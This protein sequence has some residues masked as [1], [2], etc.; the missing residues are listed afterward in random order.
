MSDYDDIKTELNSLNDKLTAQPIL[1][2]END[3]LLEKQASI[4]Q[5][6]F[7]QSRI[8]D[9]NRDQMKRTTAYTKVGILTVVSLGIILVFRLLGDIIPDSVMTMIYIILFSVCIFYGLFVYSDVNGREK[10]NYDRYD[11][12]P[13]IINLSDSEK[14]KRRDAA[15]KEGD[16]LAANDKGVCS[17]QA[18][19]DYKQAYN[20]QLNKCDNCTNTASGEG[21]YN[22]TTNACAN[23]S[24]NKK[25]DT[26]T[27]T[28][29]ACETG[30]WGEI[31]TGVFGCK[32]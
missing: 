1:K 15:L 28:C 20:G 16:L 24:D 11:I 27:K 26:T 12:A 4:I 31:T 2:A 22:K 6:K 9:L 23:C 25:W 29:I 18:C 13:P 3:R 30:T 10:T 5:A 17:G 14:K 19:C 7:G 21:Y 32:S 8:V